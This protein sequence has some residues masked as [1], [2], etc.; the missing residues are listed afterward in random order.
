MVVTG[1]YH[2]ILHR[3]SRAMYRTASHAFVISSAQVAVCKTSKFLQV[4]LSQCQKEHSGSADLH[5][6]SW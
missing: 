2:V 6:G 3:G 5:Q 4:I 1:T